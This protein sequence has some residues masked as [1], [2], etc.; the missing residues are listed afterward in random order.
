MEAQLLVPIISAVGFGIQQF[1][2]VIGDPLVSIIITAAKS[3]FGEPQPDGTRLLPWGISDV[4]AKKAM[5]GATSIFIGILIA[6]S[7]P[8]IRVLEAAG[9]TTVPWWDW[10]I[11]AL[12]ISAGTEG[13]NSVLK[14]VQYLK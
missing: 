11:T 9:L 3:S 4:D 13:A 10:F 6:T 2:Q 5:L 7:A 1:L 8:Q 14:L 12:T